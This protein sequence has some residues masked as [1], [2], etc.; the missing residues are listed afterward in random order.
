MR[1]P[2]EGRPWGRLTPWRCRHC[3]KLAW[4]PGLEEPDEAGV[5]VALLA[6]Q[7]VAKTPAS[8]RDPSTG[9]PARRRARYRYGLVTMSPWWSTAGVCEMP[10]GRAGWPVAR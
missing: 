2:A 10:A 6:L 4:L 1:L 9:S 8:T 3:R 5:G 7:P